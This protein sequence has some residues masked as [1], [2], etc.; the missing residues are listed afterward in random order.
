MKV[1]RTTQVLSAPVLF[2]I[3]A[4]VYVKVLLAWAITAAKFC[5]CMD[6][7]FDVL[8]SSC[9]QKNFSKAPACNREKGFRADWLSSR[10]ASLYYIIEFWCQMATTNRLWVANYNSGDWRTRKRPLPKLQFRLRA[11]TQTSTES[12]EKHTW[13]HKAKT[14]LQQLQCSTIFLWPEAQLH[15][16]TFNTVSIRKCREWIMAPLSGV[17]AILPHQCF[18]CE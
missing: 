3:M 14:R 13:I 2:A 10:P 7:I 12:F 9:K 4:L 6:R 15:R 1:S 16:K 5:D 18:T 17:L 11:N 8:N